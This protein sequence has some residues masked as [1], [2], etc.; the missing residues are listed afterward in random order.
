MSQ[1]DSQQQSS[2]YA[3][4]RVFLNSIIISSSKLNL[5]STLADQAE[6]K[7]CFKPLEMLTQIEEKSVEFCFA[8]DKNAILVLG[9]TGSGKSTTINFLMGKKMVQKLRSFNRYID[10]IG[11]MEVE[12]ERITTEENEDDG[13]EFKIGFKKESQTLV[14]KAKQLVNS[15]FFI[16]DTPGF[17][18][19][20]GFEVELSNSICL[21]NFIKQCKS[22]CPILTINYNDLKSVRGGSFKD[23]IA[24]FSKFIATTSMDKILYVY[25]HVPES[26]NIKRLLN[27]IIEI[28]ESLEQNS[29]P[30]LKVLFSS[31]LKSFKNKKA[32]ILNPIEDDSTKYLKIIQDLYETDQFIND[33]QNEF[34]INL[35]EDTLT[36][37]KLYSEDVLQYVTKHTQQ[38]FFIEKLLDVLNQYVQI[39]NILKVGHMQDKYKQFVTHILNYALQ[40]KEI[41]FKNLNSSKNLPSEINLRYLNQLRTCL[42]QTKKIDQNKDPH[43]LKYEFSHE[44]V[45]REIQAVIS[46]LYDQV[47]ANVDNQIQQ[48]NILQIKFKIIK[49]QQ[50]SNLSPQFENISLE[51]TKYVNQQLSNYEKEQSQFLE[52][53]LTKESEI[54]VFKEKLAKIVCTFNFFYEVETQLNFLHNCD[55]E[56]IFK[57]YQ[58]KISSLLSKQNQKFTQNM[59]EL[60]QQIENKQTPDSINFELICSN[61]QIF[62]IKA[63]LEFTENKFLSQKI[64]DC[65]DHSNKIK[66]NI[67]LLSQDMVEYLDEY[68]Q[69]KKY[70]TKYEVVIDALTLILDIDQNIK[71][72]TESNYIKITK[73][74][75]NRI[76]QT[77]NQ[78]K[79][80][81]KLIINNESG[82]EKQSQPHKILVKSMSKVKKYNQF[83]NEVQWIDEK[84]KT[85]CVQQVQENM[86]KW[87]NKYFKY[88]IE[89]CAQSIE[90]QN[91]KN[92]DSFMICLSKLEE[93]KDLIQNYQEELHKCIKNIKQQIIQYLNPVKSLIQSIINS[94]SL[95]QQSDLQKIDEYLFYKS[96]LQKMKNPCIPIKKIDISNYQKININV[97]L[98][99]SNSQINDDEFQKLTKGTDEIIIYNDFEEYF[100]EMFIEFESLFKGLSFLE[101]KNT[102]TQRNQDKGVACWKNFMSLIDFCSKECQQIIKIIG[103]D[104]F[105]E[106]ILRI[107]DHFYQLQSQYNDMINNCM[108]QDSNYLKGVSQQYE[109]LQEFVSAFSNLDSLS[110]MRNQLISIQNSKKIIKLTVQNLQQEIRLNRFSQ[111]NKLIQQLNQLEDSFS[112]N[113]LKECMQ[114]L[115]SSQSEIIKEINNLVDQ[116]K[117][118]YNINFKLIENLERLKEISRITQKYYILELDQ[119]FEKY[120]EQRLQIIN[121]NVENLQFDAVFL[122]YSQVEQLIQEIQNNYSGLTYFFFNEEF[123]CKQIV[124]KL[125]KQI[126]NI[127]LIYE[128]KK[129]FKLTQKLHSYILEAQDDEPFKGYYINALVVNLYSIEL[130]TQNELNE[131]QEQLQNTNEKS[132]LKIIF[133]RLNQLEQLCLKFQQFISQGLSPEFE[134]Q[135]K[136]LEIYTK[137]LA[138]SIE[139]NMDKLDQ[140]QK[141]I[142]HLSVYESYEDFEKTSQRLKYLQRQDIQQ[143][144]KEIED[145][146]KRIMYQ[147]EDLVNSFLNMN[148]E[149]RSSQ[150]KQIMQYFKYKSHFSSPALQKFQ[151]FLKDLEKSVDL[152]FNQPEIDYQKGESF[153]VLFDYHD[154]INLINQ[155]SQNREQTELLEKKYSLYLNDFFNFLF[156]IEKK[157]QNLIEKSNKIKSLTNLKEIYEFTFQNIDLISYCKKQNNQFQIGGET[158]SFNLY[159]LEQI[160]DDIQKYTVFIK[161]Q[162]K[163]NFQ[164]CNFNKLKQNLQTLE[165]NK[166]VNLLL[167]N[168][169]FEFEEESLNIKLEAQNLASQVIKQILEKNMDVSTFQKINIL[170]DFQEMFEST[171][172]LDISD[173]L[174]QIK[175]HLEEFLVDIINNTNILDKKCLE[176]K[177]SQCFPKQEGKAKEDLDNMIQQKMQQLFQI[178]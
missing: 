128:K 88:C 2:I 69:K 96:K 76:F 71:F 153:L 68:C 171:Q 64:K 56:S 84:L 148:Q 166:D 72:Q 59:K 151:K 158:I 22:I 34:N 15:D 124:Q 129:L 60:K 18:D 35:S 167:K 51:T 113:E 104:S 170:Y 101:K 137:D 52:D 122:Q 91:F 90:N 44:S 19:S 174:Q 25:T 146:E 121:K 164:N 140:I 114:H 9:S 12:E 99:M 161:D 165:Q 43:F 169:L 3:D 126:A 154:L 175:N 95:P 134:M 127:H 139:E 70:L 138:D 168:N 20:R 152:F 147:L 163:I 77:K 54:V 33:P 48:V 74:I 178:I 86:K 78:I 10:G 108:D 47:K 85:K 119:I 130:Y 66:E 4:S 30:E 118:N 81:I 107:S 143:Y 50:L 135:K 102:I 28:K 38:G 26:I 45:I 42:L 46:E 159:D 16:C 5:N 92:L 75:K 142:N 100:K 27:E 11:Q 97:K 131:I 63:L 83:L 109:L 111:A 40:T 116:S 23:V 144:N 41:A 115:E 103:G 149:V 160:E 162:I 110:F 156:D 13:N 145:I 67:Q 21:F 87:V 58:N 49:I 123:Q 61:Q 1:L 31:Q 155:F 7:T 14:L 32:F 112:Q 176:I 17:K 36:K 82:D 73:S 132:S 93:I 6:F 24:P 57:N 136:E 157:Q 79:Y 94:K 120:I 80:E 89:G 55:Q 37:L 173:Q 117:N 105:K 125:G 39:K 98:R 29:S 8:K 53:C 141:Q 62:E 133:L 172:E 65:Q 177:I 106:T 150:I